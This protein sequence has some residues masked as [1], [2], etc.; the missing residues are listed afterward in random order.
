MVMLSCAQVLQALLIFGASYE[1]TQAS[2][3]FY[4][5]DVFYFVKHF[6]VVLVV[7]VG[8]Y[9]VA[10]G[11]DVLRYLLRVYIIRTEN[12]AHAFAI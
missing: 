6:F 12:T 8:N 3:Y 1:I 10:I 9:G 11:F 7:K 2:I 4:S 5:S